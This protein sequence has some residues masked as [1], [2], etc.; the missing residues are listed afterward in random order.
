MGHVG[1][2]KVLLDE[3][4]QQGKRHPN[5]GATIF[6]FAARALIHR[7]LASSTPEGYRRRTSGNGPPDNRHF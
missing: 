7:D 3:G 1:I 4:V 5:A 2:N 6:Q